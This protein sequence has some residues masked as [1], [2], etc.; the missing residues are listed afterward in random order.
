MALEFGA[1]ARRCLFIEAMGT[2]DEL[3]Q[4]SP[5]YRTLHSYYM[6]QEDPAPLDAELEFEETPVA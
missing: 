5:T 1:N 6:N 3:L 4:T 2:H